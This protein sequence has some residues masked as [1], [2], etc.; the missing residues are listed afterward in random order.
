MLTRTAAFDNAVMFGGNVIQSINVQTI[1][2]GAG[3]AT[4]LSGLQPL[5]GATISLDSTSAVRRTFKAEFAD[6]DGTLGPKFGTDNLAPF[7]KELVVRIGFR[8][9]DGTTETVAAGVFGIDS[10][11]TDTYGKVQVTGRDRAGFVSDE[12]F[13]TPYVIAS[14]SNLIT[15]AQTLIQSRYP[16]TLTFVAAGTALTTTLVTY[17]EGD[18]TDPMQAAIDLLATGGFEVFFDASGQVVIRTIPDPTVAAQVWTYVAGA[19]SLLLDASW[20]LAAAEV[21]NVVVYTVEGSQIATPIR[22]VA[23]VTDTSSPIFAGATPAAGSTAPPTTRFGRKIK[24]VSQSTTAVSTQGAA[25]AVAAAL[26]RQV[27]GTGEQMQFSAAPHPC[28]EPG[29]VATVQ[30]SIL[31]GGSKLAVLAGWSLDLGLAKDAQFATLGARSS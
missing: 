17:E 8:Y 31:P 24:F 2:P 3:P 7:G 29:D 5:P 26:L 22:S 15:A 25:D 6:P 20:A 18:T 14:G 23:A 13:E 27:A 12:K 16:G 19:G 9:V 4:I 30:S 10:V 21:K 28:H 11:S 1:V